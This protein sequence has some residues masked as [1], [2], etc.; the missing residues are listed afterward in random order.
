[1]PQQTTSMKDRFRKA[2]EESK[3]KKGGTTL[4]LG[5]HA[6]RLS[7]AR[8][9][10]GDKTSVLTEW[11]CVEGDE[12]GE[13]AVRWGNTDTDEQLAFTLRDLASIGIDLDAAPDF[14]TEK[15]MFEWIDAE[16]KAK[17]EEAPGA[18]I[19][20]KEN[21]QYTNVYIDRMMDLSDKPLPEKEAETASGAAAEDETGDEGAEE[22][23]EETGDEADEPDP[24]A[25]GDSVSFIHP[26]TKKKV[27]GQVKK[28]LADDT[29]DVLPTGEKKPLNI[30]ASIAEKMAQVG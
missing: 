4:T 16:L 13:K 25:V 7:D 26:K 15:A 27:V 2:R 29:L 10:F 18:K 1:M 12:I 8:V 19:T 21:G 14:E 11:T 23:S 22:A 30:D 17:L 6:C 5:K 28:V 9:V 3:K 20:V 24:I